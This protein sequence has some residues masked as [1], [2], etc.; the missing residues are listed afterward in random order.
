MRRYFERVDNGM[1]GDILRLTQLSAI[2][3]EMLSLLTGSSSR[4][5]RSAK[6]DVRHLDA[7]L[8]QA[9]IASSL[10]NALELIDGPIVDRAAQRMSI[11]AQ[12][13]NVRSGGH[14]HVALMDWLQTSTA[15]RLLKRLTRQ[16]TA[17]AQQLLERADIVLR[18]LPADGVPLSQ[19]AAETLGNAH[20]LD[21]G[22]PTATI[23]LTASCGPENTAD[24]IGAR[25]SPPH[26][27][28]RLRLAGTADR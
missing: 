18:R 2:E 14:W 20:A 17:L 4:L 25:R 28:R 13:D 16:D 26:V 8:L 5:A 6:I 11:Q 12:W 3:H 23:I 19:L 1:V 15:I 24:S 7:A 21:R 27:P 9:G 22:E 10:R